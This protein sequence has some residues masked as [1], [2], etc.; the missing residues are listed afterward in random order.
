MR[1]PGVY[2]DFMRLRRNTKINL[3]IPVEFENDGAAPGLK[4]GGVLTVVRPEIELVVTAGDIPEK[5]TADLTGLEIGDTIAII[6]IHA[7]YPVC[8]RKSKH[9]IFN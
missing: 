8:L 5:V 3:F 4:R 1:I 9:S 6:I 2:V 7:K